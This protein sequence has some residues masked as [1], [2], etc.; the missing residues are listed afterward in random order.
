MVQDDGAP[1]TR[2]GPDTIPKI[3][4]NSFSKTK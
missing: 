1:V 4:Q 3:F 2:Y